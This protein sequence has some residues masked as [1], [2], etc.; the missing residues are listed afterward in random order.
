MTAMELHKR[1]WWA[2]ALGL[3]VVLSQ[4]AAII[5]LARNGIAKMP[6]KPL[7]QWGCRGR[8][9]NEVLTV[10]ESREG[11][12]IVFRAL[13]LKS[14]QL[15]DISLEIPVFRPMCGLI[16]DKND[17]W[18]IYPNQVT[19]TDGREKQ[20]YK[21]Q[22]TLVLPLS[23]AFLY[24]GQPA[25]IDLDDD[26]V[27]YCLRTFQDG[28]WHRAG[29]VAIPGMNRKW[30][31]SES[32]GQSILQPG[33]RLPPATGAANNHYLTIFAADDVL[34]LFYRD[35]SGAITAYREGLD[36]I[37]VDSVFATALAPENTPAETTGW[38]NLGLVPGLS[39]IVFQPN[40]LVM[41]EHERQGSP[42]RFWEKPLD[43]A[44]PPFRMTLELKSSA[45]ESLAL[46]ESPERDELYFIRG[47]EW[48]PSVQRYRDG[49][50]QELSQPWE[51]DLTRTAG[52][53]LAVSQPFLIV[54][55]LANLAILA[56]SE[57]ISRLEIAPFEHGPRKFA[58][59]S[60]S[61]RAL[62]RSLDLALLLA[63]AVWHLSHLGFRR[64]V[65]DTYEFFVGAMIPQ[66]ATGQALSQS[67]VW[68]ALV[69]VILI[70]CQGRWGQTPG[71]WICGIKVL[72]S[73]SY[74][75]GL[76]RSLMRELMLV[77]DAPGIT[78]L[79]GI[80]CLLLNDHRQRIG[81]LMAD[82][83]VVNVRELTIADQGK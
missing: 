31:T 39:S 9:S 58:L 32:T 79:P 44:N 57:W 77:L 2:I 22:R 40:R 43:S 42:I 71:K 81:D 73:T 48:N 53:I 83:V 37:P 10:R 49:Q 3:F 4:V 55:L 41:V 25:I 24:K 45:W 34:H 47:R 19:R 38:T 26:G 13:D 68:F 51:S 63:V 74:P 29:E 76:A 1:A 82:T 78:I 20:D 12:F 27:K 21:P 56:G 18:E 6:V 11:T 62:A 50:L 75:C 60:V 66:T 46:V 65:I 15:G 36:L 5:L 8:T 16:A 30:V 17:V 54:L 23:G 7:I 33:V 61:R 35:N 72:R 80:I 69:A 52:W 14:G 70:A 64:I 28:E 67:A 59:A